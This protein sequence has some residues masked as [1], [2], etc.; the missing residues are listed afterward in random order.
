[1][2]P[3]INS[4]VKAHIPHTLHQYDHDE[5]VESYGLEAA[6]KLGFAEQQVFKTLVVKVDQ[7]YFAVALIPV[8]AKL[9]MKRVAKAL[10]AKKV[11]MADKKDVER[12]TGYVTGGISPLGQKT[13]LKTL[14]D[15]SAE[16]F[17]EIYVSAGR[18]GLEIGINPEHLKGLT[19]GLYADLC[20]P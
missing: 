12:V 13:R 5:R 1:M 9:N 15:Q 19:E 3:A 8:C 6:D 2:T 20:Q 16:V 14:I 17:D 10:S 7:K 11:F 18:R 4:V